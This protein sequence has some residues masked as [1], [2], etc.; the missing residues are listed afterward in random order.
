MQKVCTFLRQRANTKGGEH[1]IIFMTFPLTLMCSLALIT[2][3][4]LSRLRHFA[5]EWNLFNTKLIYLDCDI[6]AGWLARS[7][8]QS[9]R[10]L[11]MH[12]L[13][14][15]NENVHND[16][17]FTFLHFNTFNKKKSELYHIKFVVAAVTV[18]VCNGAS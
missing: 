2:C 18:A 15:S 6:R 16:D 1:P 13:C 5:S 11:L 9:I 10:L 14:V 4:H 3:L 12:I 7:H 8:T 17:F